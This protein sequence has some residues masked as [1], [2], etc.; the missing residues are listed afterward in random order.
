MFTSWEHLFAD[1]Q[2]N[3]SIALEMDAFNQE[4]DNTLN[5][6]SNDCMKFSSTEKEYNKSENNQPYIENPD[7][8]KKIRLNSTKW[9]KI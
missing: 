1:I 3:E 4:P 6:S 5:Q 8:T 2:W 9:N 7:Y